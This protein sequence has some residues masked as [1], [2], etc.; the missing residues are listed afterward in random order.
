MLDGTLEVW[1]RMEMSTPEDGTCNMTTWIWHVISFH[2]SKVCM[3]NRA[4]HRSS[5]CLSQHRCKF[6]TSETRPKQSIDTEGYPNVIWFLIYCKDVHHSR[7]SSISSFLPAPRYKVG[8]QGM[9]ARH[10]MFACLKLFDLLNWLSEPLIM[11]DGTLKVWCR[12]EMSTPEDDEDG[13]CSTTTWIW[14]V[15]S[16]HHGKVAC[17]VGQ[18]IDPVFAYSTAGAS[19]AHQKL[20][21]N[22]GLT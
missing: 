20:G 12:M 5:V 17:V 19:S 9:A 10:R 14:Y 15:I 21:L 2:H 13:T 16:L 7:L 4:S 6:C 11:L 3:R 22:N 1:C 8:L 18:G